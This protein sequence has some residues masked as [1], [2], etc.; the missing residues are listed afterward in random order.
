MKQAKPHKIPHKNRR[1]LPIESPLTSLA[2][3]EECGDT[4]LTS[5]SLKSSK[6]RAVC[7]IVSTF[8]GN[9]KRYGSGCLIHP[10]WV[11]TAGHVVFN[12]GPDPTKPLAKSVNM[13][14]SAEG[15]VNPYGAL[16]SDDFRVFP[17]WTTSPSPSNDLALVRI[18]NQTLYSRV[19]STIP[20]SL[21][22]DSQDIV[23]VGY[24]VRPTVLAYRNDGDGILSGNLLEYRLNSE[25]GMSGGP[26]I[27][28][29]AV[30]GVHGYGTCPNSGLAI[31][32]K[33]LDWIK[34][35]LG[36]MP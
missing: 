15:G 6:Y 20:L 26:V 23:L 12:T 3:L 25:S 24:P 9:Q 33:V 27:R 35:I 13:A 10:L 22:T 4:D 30:V 36:E 32:Q 28:D 31:T 21:A 5:I 1:I 11:L 18:P 29:L 14:P 34:S 16:D 19:Q 8:S 7:R 17:G 2:S